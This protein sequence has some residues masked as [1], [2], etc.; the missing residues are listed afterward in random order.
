[1]EIDNTLDLQDYLE[2]TGD[3]AKRTRTLTILITVASV[4]VFVGIMNSYS[5]NWAAERMRTIGRAGQALGKPLESRTE[6]DRKDIAYLETLLG[7]CPD[8]LKTGI[9]SDG[10]AEAYRKQYEEFFTS[11]VRAYVEN[12]LTI[13]VPFFGVAFDV[14]YL[15]LFGGLGLSIL[16]LLYRFSINRETENLRLSFAKAIELDRLPAFYE[17]LSMRQVFTLPPREGDEKKHPLR[18][19]PR[20]LS[21]LPFVVF[22]GLT[23]FDITSSKSVESVSERLASLAVGI[24]LLFSVVIFSL[25]FW[26][27]K[28]GSK[29]DV[30]WHKYW[31]EVSKKKAS[32]TTPVPITHQHS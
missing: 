7:P 8:S 16:L 17:L 9:T 2:A 20:I 14:N 21:T 22:I 31:A 6:D 32:D 29:I 27:V 18:Y 15:G 19:A 5:G 3:A 11:V 30:L 28:E 24:D 25:T 4:L 1:M 10:G 26:C 23:A 12:T 13:R